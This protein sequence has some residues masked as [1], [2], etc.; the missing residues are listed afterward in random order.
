MRSNES[1]KEL[2]QFAVVFANGHRANFAICH[3]SF[4][5]SKGKR[6]NACSSPISGS[7][8]PDSQATARAKQAG[9]FPLFNCPTL[10]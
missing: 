2:E 7:E 3:V 9:H 6:T 4:A 10:K 1:D 8:R 5:K